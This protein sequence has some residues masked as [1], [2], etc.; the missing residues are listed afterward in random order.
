MKKLAISLA[1]VLALATTLR[2]QDANRIETVDTVPPTPA[3]ATPAEP[4]PELTPQMYRYLVDMQRYHA[5]ID[6]PRQRAQLKAQQRMERMAAMK[7]Y[8]LSNARPTATAT[9]FMGST[10]APRWVGN[11][12]SG[13]WSDRGYYRAFSSQ[14]PQAETIQR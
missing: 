14:P 1:L 4:K 3:L 8:G 12:Y 5:P 6:L 13:N 2:G 10:F 11:S 7:W 9:P